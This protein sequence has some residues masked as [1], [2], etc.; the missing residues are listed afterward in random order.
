MRSGDRAAAFAAIGAWELGR[1]L[2]PAGGARR[3]PLSLALQGGGA[4]GAFTWGVLDRLLEEDGIGF[5]VLGGASAGAVNA[6][7]LADGLRK[8]GAAAAREGLAH[9]WRRASGMAPFAGL[10]RGAQKLALAAFE[11]S[12]P[13]LSPYQLN[14]L[15]LNPL[16]DI[17]AETVDFAALRGASPVRLIV[18][19]TRVSDGCPRLFR[20]RELTLEAVLASACLP[21]LHR[22]VEI[23]GEAYWDGGFSANPPL[24]QLVLESKARE[25]VLVE[26]AAAA[27]AGAPRSSAAIS[28]R[29]KEFAVNG[30]LLRDIEALDELRSLC[31]RE[32]VFRSALCRKLRR[33][34][35]HRIAAQEEFARLDPARALDLDW[36]FLTRLKDSGRRAA[37]G[38]LAGAESAS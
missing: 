7:I 13:F 30:P 14:P 8:G 24:R 33:L 34:T 4:F 17:L 27:P 6:V 1:M 21:F 11:M 9:F 22:A 2:R 20:E 19:A 38:W 28:R 12:A 25:V 5:D 35:L 29:V 32:G 31:R 18:A 15:D 26:L 10:G 3:R 23:E 16:R 36:G 37:A